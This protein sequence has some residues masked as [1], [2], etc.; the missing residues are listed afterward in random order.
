[1]TDV[2]SGAAPEGVSA[3]VPAPTGE[4]TVSEAVAFL[5][6]RREAPE[7]REEAPPEAADRHQSGDEPDAAPPQE[8]SGETTDADDPAGEQP[9]A[10]PRSWTKADKELFSS[11]PRETQ[12]RLVELDRTREL[13][14]RRGQNEAAER[15]KALE[16]KERAAEQ[17][18]QQYE[19]ALPQVLATAQSDYERYFGDIRTWDDVQ[20]LA[21]EN[22]S[23]YAEWD[24]A[25]RRLQQVQAQ[26]EQAEQQRYEESVN[27]F[28]TFVEKETGLFLEKYPDYGD[29]KKGAALRDETRQMLLSTG[30]K[31]EE[32][33][34]AFEGQQFS[35][36]DHRVQ[37]LIEKARRYDVAQQALSRK[38]ANPVPPVQ[39]PGVAPAKGEARATELNQLH[40]KLEKSGSERD[41]VALL[42]ARR[43][44]S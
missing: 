22:P 23:R 8:P 12:E 31:P 44:A 5:A 3:P 33:K 21:Q 24:V 19:A 34:A 29:P 39:R 42:R 27:T 28:K 13:E 30:F 4:A 35:F 1:M 43:R 36:H 15:A 7:Q 11:L 2:S 20:R 25:T 38:P 18:R 41:A 14:I 17:A 40:S 26:H 10:P 9:I 6:K 32:L 16:A 37:T